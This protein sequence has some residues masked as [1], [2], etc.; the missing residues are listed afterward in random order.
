[1]PFFSAWETSAKALARR[2]RRAKTADRSETL[3]AAGSRPDGF[4][5]GAATDSKASSSMNT[6]VHT[7]CAVRSASGTAA[8]SA[9]SQRCWLR[10]PLSGSWRSAPRKTLGAPPRASTSKLSRRRAPPQSVRSDSCAAARAAR[11]LMR[12]LPSKLSASSAGSDVTLPRL[13]QPNVQ[14]SVQGRADLL[15]LGGA[16]LVA[17]STSFPR[18]SPQRRAPRRCGRLLTVRADPRAR[19]RPWGGRARGRRS[20]GTPPRRRPW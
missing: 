11:A 17:M 10:R 16:C 9:R 5:D 19:R 4:L 2:T 6:S 14:P 1:M 7:N 13:K 12:A 8:S 18:A 3:A 15:H 20:A